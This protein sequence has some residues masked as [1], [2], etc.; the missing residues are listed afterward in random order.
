MKKKK[1]YIYIYNGQNLGTVS[2]V[3]YIRFPI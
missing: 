2:Y 3:Q 1:K